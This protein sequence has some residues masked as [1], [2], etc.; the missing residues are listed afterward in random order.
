MRKFG[1]ITL[2]AFYLLLTTGIF[3]CM[4]HC[5]AGY[6]FDKIAGTE[7]THHD[8]GGGHHHRVLANAKGHGHKKSCGNDKDC[9]CCNQHGNYVIKENVNGGFEFQLT[10]LQVA[11]HILPHQLLPVERDVYYQKFCWPSTTG[12]P[13]VSNKPLYIFYRSLLI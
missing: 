12:P 7:I 11:V 2:A 6:L 5:G 13:L 8:A 9:S 3:V 10:P 4:V 1:A